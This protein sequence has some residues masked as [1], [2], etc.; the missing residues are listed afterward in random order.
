MHYAWNNLQKLTEKLNSQCVSPQHK[1]LFIWPRAFCICPSCL[2]PLC[3]EASAL[4]FSC[5]YLC[6]TPYVWIVLTL[7]RH[8][9][10]S[11]PG[12]VDSLVL[13]LT[14]SIAK[15]TAGWVLQARYIIRLQMLATACLNLVRSIA[16]R[17]VKIKQIR[18]NFYFYEPICGS[19][20]KNTVP[21][22]TPCTILLTSFLNC[23]K[24]LPLLIWV[25]RG[26]LWPLLT[27]SDSS[28]KERP[29]HV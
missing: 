19:F 29:V 1:I 14:D 15:K 23:H 16:N 21:L 7:Q 6:L 28:V 18:I 2:S 12:T 27:V 22:C 8:T 20:W 9:L 17:A 3:F 4:P 25:K 24:I 5:L 11:T 26:T 10:D 13:V